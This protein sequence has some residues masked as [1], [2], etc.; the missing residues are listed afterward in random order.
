MGTEEAPGEEEALLRRAARYVWALLLARIDEVL[1]L[2]CPR[3]GGEMRIIAFLT[4]ACAVRDILTH[5]GE[6]TSPPRLMPARAP[7]L[8][9]RLDATMGEDDPQAQPAPEFQFDQR[10]A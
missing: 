1:P 9:E 3:C 8:W 6:P 4:D 5:L 10:I 2:V 7:P